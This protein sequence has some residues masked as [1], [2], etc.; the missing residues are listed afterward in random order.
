MAL[1]NDVPDR[2]VLQAYSPIDVPHCQHEYD[3]RVVVSSTTFSTE[4]RDFYF[5]VV[6]LSLSTA[7]DL[8]SVNLHSPN[9]SINSTHSA[10][11]ARHT[12][13]AFCVE[14]RER[15]GEADRFLLRVCGSERRTRR[16]QN[17]MV[18]EM[19]GG[20]SDS[21]KSFHL[22]ALQVLIPA[23]SSSARGGIHAEGSR[24]GAVHERIVP[25][26]QV[27][28]G[29][30]NLLRTPSKQTHSGCPVGVAFEKA[31][32]LIQ[33]QPLTLLLPEHERSR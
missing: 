23:A 1:A 3:L 24:P 17:K 26:M 30:T 13:A 25:D 16:E 22:H 11:N 29:D 4:E 18:Q 6:N 28:C 20:E 2:A 32:P 12:A 19:Q 7:S 5:K 27:E 9:T 31:L 21:K 10:P 8:E 33:A 14:R 15:V